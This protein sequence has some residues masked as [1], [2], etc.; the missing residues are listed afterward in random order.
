MRLVL[1]IFFMV[2]VGLAQENTLVGRLPDPTQS[3]DSAQSGMRFWKISAAALVSASALDIASSWGKC[4]EGNSLLA[5]P[6]RRFGARGLTIKSGALGGQLLLQYLVA[7]KHPKLAR[8]LGFVNIA[9]AGAITAVAIHN[10]GIP[11]RP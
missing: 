3:M 2:F 1:G 7:R 5:S 11:Q 6:D 8:V 9:G 4:C 10:Y